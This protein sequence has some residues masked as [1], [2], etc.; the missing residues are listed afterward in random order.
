MINC[1]IFDT[2]F[3]NCFIIYRIWG[4]LKG[5]NQKKNQDQQ[6][7]LERM[8]EGFLKGEIG[9]RKVEGIH[10]EDFQIIID[11][12]AHLFFF[13]KSKNGGKLGIEGLA[14]YDGM[15]VEFSDVHAYPAIKKDRK[16]NY[17]IIVLP[18]IKDSEEAKQLRAR[19][20]IKEFDCLEV[21]EKY[22]LCLRIFHTFS[23]SELITLAREYDPLKRDTSALELRLNERAKKRAQGTHGQE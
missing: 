7:P 5:V 11:S 9:P 16:S 14:D 10:P 18:D 1:L 6:T 3:Y 23:E 22:E 17:K 15:R 12:I 19:E 21:V 4:R 20:A 2:V 13:Q 8:V